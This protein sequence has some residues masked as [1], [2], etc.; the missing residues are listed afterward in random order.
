MI[1]KKGK[2]RKE[3]VH[4]TVL[5]FTLIEHKKGSRVLPRPTDHRPSISCVSHIS[6]IKYPTPPLFQ[7]PPAFLP[8]PPKLLLHSQIPPIFLSLIGRRTH[9]QTYIHPYIPTYTQTNTGITD[10]FSPCHTKHKE[11]K[12]STFSAP[13]LSKNSLSNLSSPS[14]VTPNLRLIM[15]QNFPTKIL[16]KFFNFF[17]CY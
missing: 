14:S 11:I 17:F 16:K 6:L 8:Q 4:F 12:L 15:I 1:R 13:F 3:E 10:S 2:R 5:P 9:K 7:Q